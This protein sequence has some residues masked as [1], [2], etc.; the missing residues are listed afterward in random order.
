L[1][2]KDKAGNALTATNGTVMNNVSDFSKEYEIVFDKVGEFSLTYTVSDGYNTE[3]K[4][5][6][7]YVKDNIPPQITLKEATTLAK[8]G[9]NVTIAN[10]QVTDPTDT[11]VSVRVCVQRP[12]MGVVNLSGRTFKA[13]IKGTYTVMYFATDAT[14]NSA[15]AYY[16][17]VVK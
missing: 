9:S 7:I 13:D 1:S 3:K 12:D 14:G 10:Y 17:V 4:T 16:E 11:N 6:V 8:V 15:F 2:L 5:V